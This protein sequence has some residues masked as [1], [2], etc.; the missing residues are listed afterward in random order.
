MPPTTGSSSIRLRRLWCG[1]IA[2]ASLALIFHANAQQ[3]S[4]APAALQPPPNSTPG[5][6]TTVD[7]IQRMISRGQLSEAETRL[8]TLA[9]QQPEPAGV[10]RMRGMIHYQ[11]NE[12]AAANTAFE[13][14]IAQQSSDLQAVQMRGVTLYRMGQ[15]AAAIPL[16]ERANTTIAS[17]NADGT[18]VLAVC[19]LDVHRYD[20]ARRIFAKQYKLPDDSAA[21]YLFVGRMLLRRNYPAESE[22]MARKALEIDPRLPLAHLLLGQ[23]ALSRSREADAIVEFE[24]ERT[25]NPM[26][27][28]VYEHLGDSYL[29]ASRF[30]DAQQALNCAL[31][32]EPNATGPY[33]LLGQVLL[34]RDD[35]LTALN[36][37]THAER[38]DPG[39]HLTHLMLGQAY[40]ALGRKDDATREYKSAESIQSSSE[41]QQ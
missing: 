22:Q 26:D 5:D 4:P 40:R 35:P 2:S 3:S 41:N 27:G 29:R 28:E 17:V 21:S 20:D 18:Y 1:L 19:Y 37:L 30:E 39:N 24:A 10:E 16:L 23:L 33:I 36:Y 15:P 25:I 6:A 12:F 7:D 34:K 31:L 32:L 11:R 9:T 38:M 8:N 14:A 13:K